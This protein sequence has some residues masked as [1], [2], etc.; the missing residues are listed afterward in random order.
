MGCT[1]Q[2]SPQIARAA[3]RGAEIAAKLGLTLSFDPNIRP[4]L[5]RD[6]ETR[7]IFERILHQLP[8]F[9]PGRANCCISRAALRWRRAPKR[10][11]KRRRRLW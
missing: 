3:L 5:L 8:L 10:C 4:E 1:L 2:A 9:S 11:W 7:E 6:G